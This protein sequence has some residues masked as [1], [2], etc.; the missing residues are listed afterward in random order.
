MTV[1]FE[2]D[3]GLG[4]G[5]SVTEWWSRDRREA[6]HQSDAVRHALRW[7]HP[8]SIPAPPK[9]QLLRRREG[10][11]MHLGRGGRFARGPAHG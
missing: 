4:G 5:Q 10:W 11:R 3:P 6:A 1:H 7:G 2:T 8:V 9:T